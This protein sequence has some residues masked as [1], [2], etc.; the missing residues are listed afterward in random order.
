MVTACNELFE[1]SLILMG[2]FGDNEFNYAF[3][4]GITTE[5]IRG[6]VPNII[7]VISSAIQIITRLQY[8]FIVLQGC[9]DLIALLQHAVEVEVLT[10]ITRHFAKVDR[11]QRLAQH[12]PFPALP[13]ILIC[14]IELR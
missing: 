13:T 8:N 2:E 5:V 4:L 11:V 1:N 3:S 12:P 14:K 7:N 9:L 10:I 6:L